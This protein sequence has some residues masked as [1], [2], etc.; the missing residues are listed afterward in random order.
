MAYHQHQQCDTYFVE[1]YDTYPPRS[2][3]DYIKMI[4][5]RRQE[6]MADELSRQAS[7]TYLDDIVGHMKQM[8]VNSLDFQLCF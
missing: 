2:S 5:R 7:E 4:G 8:E 6:A 1:S 3:Q